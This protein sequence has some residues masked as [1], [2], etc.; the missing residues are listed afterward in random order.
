[1]GERSVNA[2]TSTPRADFIQET[3]NDVYSA[4]PWRFASATA[5][6]SISNGIATLP[7]NY[8]DNH[9]SFVKFGDIYE[10]R[11]DP[12]HQDDANQVVDGDRAQWISVLDDGVTYLLNTKDSD[13][14][15]VSFRYQKQAPILDTA[16]TIGTPY[17]S[18][19]TL[20]YGARRFVKLGQ[21]PDA[22]LSQDQKL[23]EK[24]L[25]SDIAAHQVPAARKR[26]RTAHGQ[27][28]T[29]TGDF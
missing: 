8:D 21:N 29:A 27:T 26:R 9:A 25:Q 28:G 4:Y 17:P 14:T 3:L 24:A 2:S 13:A 10:T 16:G 18:K 12:I 6:L 20:A 7:T 23:Y 11:L 22:D 5:T 19:M 15:T 1:M